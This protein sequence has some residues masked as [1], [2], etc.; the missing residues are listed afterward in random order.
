MA[1]LLI[2]DLNKSNLKVI[3]F[4][5]NEKQLIKSACKNSREAQRLLYEKHAPKMLSV[6]RQYIKDIHFAEEAMLNGFFKVFKNLKTFKFEG[7]FEG[8]VRKIMVRESISFLRKKQRLVF[9]EDYDNTF[10]ADVVVIETDLDVHH[11]QRMIDSL[12]EGYKTVF[13]M[14]AIEGYKHKEIAELLQIS[15]ST[16]KNQLFKARKVLQERIVKEKIMENGTN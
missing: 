1:S 9:V 4:Y 5:K 8:W 14:Y 13:V 2:D 15:E 6:C 12:P 3:N 11:L 7:S 10:V 16:S